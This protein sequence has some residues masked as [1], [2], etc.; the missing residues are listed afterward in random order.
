MHKE[1][2]AHGMATPATL[3][4]K[5]HALGRWPT[6]W[7]TTTRTC[8]EAACSESI[9][10]CP[11]KVGHQEAIDARTTAPLEQG[12]HASSQDT[13]DLCAIC[14]AQVGKRQPV[15]FLHPQRPLPRPRQL[16]RTLIWAT[17]QNFVQ[18]WP[19]DK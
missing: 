7:S 18:A 1:I 2:A 16:A 9:F 19:C 6:G 8:A 5:S 17:I 12:S 4:A 13:A 11:P 10:E 3:R 14:N 15:K